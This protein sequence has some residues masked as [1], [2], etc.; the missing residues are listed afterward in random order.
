[1]SLEMVNL[2][3]PFRVY[4]DRADECRTKTG[5]NNESGRLWTSV[6][7]GLDVTHDR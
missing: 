3:G 5:A 4:L 6:T 7:L 1:M 2:D